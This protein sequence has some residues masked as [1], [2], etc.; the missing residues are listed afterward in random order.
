MTSKEIADI[1]SKQA[2]L[3]YH[4]HTLDDEVSNNHNYIVKIATSVGN[5]YE[6]THQSFRNLSEKLRN[7]ESRRS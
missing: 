6:L 2:L 7:F 4:M 1:K 3:Y 5:I